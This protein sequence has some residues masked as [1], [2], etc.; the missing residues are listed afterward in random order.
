MTIHTLICLCTSPEF[1]MAGDR[2]GRN[3]RSLDQVLTMVDRRFERQ[4]RSL[5]IGPS[6]PHGLFCT[7]GR[8][9]T[10]SA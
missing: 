7:P 1:P 2:M 3:C 6:V 5:T 4:E 9:V 10:I 8:R